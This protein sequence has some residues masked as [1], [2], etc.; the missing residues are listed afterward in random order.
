MKCL[1]DFEEKIHSCSKCGLCQSVC[2]IYKCT[3]N[4]CTVSRGQFIMLRGLIKGDLEMSKTINRYLDLCLKCGECT[5]FCP[6]GI[7]VV[8]IITAAKAEYYKKSRYERLVSW[9][10]KNIILGFVLKIFSHFIQKPIS[11]KFDKKVVYFGGCGGKLGLGKSVVKL[12]NSVN[13]EVITPDFE[14]CGLPFYMRG[15]FETFEYHVKSFLDK[16]GELVSED[17]PVEIVT[18]CASCEKMLKSYA[19]WSNKGGYVVKNLF[20]YLRENEYKPELK[21]LQKVT[22]HKPC[23][24]ENFSDIEWVL[25]NTKNLCW[26]LL[27]F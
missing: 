17:N 19:K 14:C 4:D 18:N 21:S 23:N 25:K 1:A 7:D 10:L 2:P 9:I 6:A 27:R 24:M 8:D 13:I 3:G 22:Y 5:K 12:L 26:D 11:K 20:E 16:L 15:D